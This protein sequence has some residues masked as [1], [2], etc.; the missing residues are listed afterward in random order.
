M[1][2][3]YH[4]LRI[5]F[6]P[7]CSS[8]CAACI[9]HFAIPYVTGGNQSTTLTT[10]S[11]LATFYVSPDDR[12]TAGD[13]SNAREKGFISGRKTQGQFSDTSSQFLI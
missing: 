3:S 12:Q 2:K 1:A 13:P 6:S 9:G 7:L 10:F 8:F 4:Y 5:P 11:R